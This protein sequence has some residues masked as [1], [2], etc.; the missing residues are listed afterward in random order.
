MRSDLNGSELVAVASTAARELPAGHS[1]VE[2]RTRR[3]PGEKEANF[4]KL[5][6]LFRI[7]LNEGDHA[8]MRALGDRVA[9]LWC[10]SMHPAPMWPVQ[11]HYRC[12][13]C[14]RSYPVLWERTAAAA[15]HGKEG[16][17]AASSH[18]AAATAATR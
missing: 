4:P 8:T 2:D 17:V 9:R 10:K 16:R 11:G 5:R 15:R 12:P 14:L 18:R 6:A 3:I 7:Q 1:P 13:L